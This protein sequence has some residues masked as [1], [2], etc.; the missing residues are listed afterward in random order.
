ME[1]FQIELK[2]LISNCTQSSLES[3]RENNH[4][5]KK[6]NF[7]TFFDSSCYGCQ[8]A[9]FVSGSN[10][11]SPV[12]LRLANAISSCKKGCYGY[13]LCILLRVCVS[14]AYLGGLESRF[15]GF[16]SLKNSIELEEYFLIFIALLFSIRKDLIMF[17]KR[18][19]NYLFFKE[20]KRYIVTI[21]AYKNA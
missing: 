12:L 11:N 19:Y 16:C 6:N 9:S 13:Y 15:C 21:V 7:E 2:L 17:D 3:T 14:N 1:A 4:R 5:V 8:S 20:L 18:K 10:L